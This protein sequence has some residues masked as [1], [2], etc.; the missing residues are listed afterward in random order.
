MPE[1]L[2]LPYSPWSE[3]ASWALDVRAIRY[4]HR[5]Y[6]PLLGEPALRLKLR[7]WTGRV[8][9]PVLTTDDGRVIA[10]STEI[11]RWA[12]RHGSGPTLFP[13]GDDAVIS[14]MVALADRGLAAGRARSLIQ[15]MDD[16][17]GTREMVPRPL[18]RVP[19]AASLARAGLARTL[20][21]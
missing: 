13:P 10:D 15:L 6:Q 4:T 20:H 3:R 12:D 11:G 7:T 18:R 14:R 9:V 2:G 21:N 8:S 17:A 1:L 16:P 5:R 19:G